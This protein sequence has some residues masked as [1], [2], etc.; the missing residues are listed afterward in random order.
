MF[1]TFLTFR[2]ALPCHT[3]SS[4]K[5]AEENAK[6]RHCSDMGAGSGMPPLS[7]M[8]HWRLPHSKQSV[9]K[10]ETVGR[11]KYAVGRQRLP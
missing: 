4:E 3:T 10:M 7:R 8:E 2:A 5:S 11:P 1:L 6:S 9:M